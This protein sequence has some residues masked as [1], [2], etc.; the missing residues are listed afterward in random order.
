M[1][2]LSGARYAPGQWV[3]WHDEEED[4]L[5]RGQVIAVHAVSSAANEWKVSYTI[6][7]RGYVVPS[8]VEQDRLESVTTYSVRFPAIEAPAEEVAS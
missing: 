2:Y 3:Y 8:H 4:A 5:I 6:K 1:A 7:R